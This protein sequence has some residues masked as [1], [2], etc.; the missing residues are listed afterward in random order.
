MQNKKQEE[1]K[2]MQNLLKN[3][4]PALRKACRSAI[5]LL[6]AAIVEDMK[7]GVRCSVRKSVRRRTRRGL[8][9][10]SQFFVNCM[11]LNESHSITDPKTGARV[12]CTSAA[13]HDPNGVRRFS[14]SKHPRRSFNKSGLCARDLR[15]VFCR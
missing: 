15:A 4:S 12:T 14:I 2:T 11:G 3:G 1:K 7:Q 9:K 10:T 6:K 13:C 8:A 5:A